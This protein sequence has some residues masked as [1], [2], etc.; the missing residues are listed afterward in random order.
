MTDIDK[1]QQLWNSQQIT[2]PDEMPDMHR[3][4]RA[5]AFSEQFKAQRRTIF[6]ITLLMMPLT[7]MALEEMQAPLWLTAW[8]EAVML[9]L[10]VLNLSL[11][12]KVRRL[13]LGSLDIRSAVT[14]V[15]DI[16]RRLNLTVV[17]GLSI[18]IPVVISLLW[19]MFRQ[20]GSYALAGGFAGGIFGA[21]IGL[22]IRRRSLWF[23]YKMQSTLS[24]TD[25]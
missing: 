3:L 22:A 4:R 24:D 11:W 16:R 12:L 2:P 14:K 17:I 15:R 23:I 10:C 25:D 5:G 1:I 9:A 19:I 6:V 18:A 20:D 7:Y 21:A 13:D 8:Y